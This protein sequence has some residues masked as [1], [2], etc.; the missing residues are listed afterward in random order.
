MKKLS[1]YV[2]QYKGGFLLG[3][4]SLL[5]AVTLDMIFPQVTRKIVDNVIIGGQ[6][7]KLPTLLLVLLGLGLGRFVFEYLKE[8]SFDRMG[9]RV[10]TSMRKDLFRFLQSLS[11]DFFDR[12]NTGELMARMK[13]DI[14]NIWQ[15]LTF[16]TMLLIQVF[17]HT[18]L[19]LVCMIRLNPLMTIIPAVAMFLS[20]FLAVYMEHKLG[21]VYDEMS[22]Q[23]AKM[24]T[25][26]EENLSGV[27]TVKAFAREKF[28][29]R[30]FLD[31]NE[32]YYD[33]SIQQSKVF[34]R[35]YPYF[36]IITRI[37]PLLVML[38]GGVQYMH[39]KMS[40]GDLAAFIEYSMNIVWPM[41]ML[42][43]LSN[44]FSSAVT[45]NKKLKKIYAEVPSITEP[46]NP[47]VLPGVQ[48]SIT[49]DHVSFAKADR[50]P[51]L[52]D[53][54]FSVHAGETVG[55]MGATGAGKSSIIHLLQR[56]YDVTEG[57][58]LLD[59][60]DIRSLSL[61]QLR[62]SMS[63]VSQDVFL[64]SDTI[65]ENIRLGKH[66]LIDAKTVRLASRKAQAADFIEAMEDQYETLI[67]ER[68]VGL[69]GGQ[70]QRISIARAIAKK[71]PILILDDS[72]SALDMETEHE[73]QKTLNEMKN[74]TKVIVAHRI[75]SVRRANL[76]L[77]LENGRI[78]EQ[79]THEELLAKRG[80]YYDTYMAQYG[81]YIQDE[82]VI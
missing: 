51:I 50:V 13:D 27:R 42:G 75:S 65:S 78:A 35:Y 71:N 76:I 43:W 37:L 29:I 18:V 6:L 11:A 46:E 3:L 61:H 26:A 36:Q 70:K 55:I 73:I 10:A 80:L 81:A 24:N 19:I 58:I 49:F 64:F 39:N 45:S 74:I 25:V 9:S 32:K 66:D 53:I 82:E 15:S 68:G 40:L 23:N 67:G 20:G 56:M 54:T 17:Y 44:S 12:S 34:I 4:V 7:G 79:G 16:V 1:T 41:E 31:H 60:T 38:I 14:S 72:T 5:I 21:R 47:V 28:E 52:T 2:W 48:G 63:L 59:G 22:E 8:Y 77:F 57:A 69:S 62:T 33:L 30:K